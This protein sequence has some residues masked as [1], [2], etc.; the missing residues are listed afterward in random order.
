[1]SAAIRIN[2]AI[3]S[4]QKSG[5][6][7]TEST[8]IRA[9]TSSPSRRIRGR[10][11]FILQSSSQALPRVQGRFFFVLDN[12][13]MHSHQHIV[14]WARLAAF[15]LFSCSSHTNIQISIPPTIFN[16]FVLA[17]ARD[18]R[19]IEYTNLNCHAQ[20][21]AHCPCVTAFFTMLLF[22]CCSPIMAIHS[23]T[24]HHITI[25]RWQALK[26]FSCKLPSRNETLT[27]PEH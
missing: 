14:T 6:V 13:F 1:M 11:F 9:R 2:F 7:V 10:I 23:P 24:C 21:V 26:V 25:Q 15:S 12:R 27:Q 19:L 4:L 8:S 16:V 18:L 5:L 20:I 22:T 3:A 17:V